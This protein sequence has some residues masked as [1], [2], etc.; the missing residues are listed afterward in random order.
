MIDWKSLFKSKSYWIDKIQNDLYGQV[1]QY[2][3]ENGM[4]KL[5]LAKQLGVSKGYVSQILNGQFDHKLSKL[6]ELYLAIGKAP[7][8][9]DADL[10]RYAAATAEGVPTYKFIADL[11][12]MQGIQSQDGFQSG[13]KGFM[14]AT[15]NMLEATFKGTDTNTDAQSMLSVQTIGA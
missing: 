14:E 5:D 8:I 3:K 10:R 9:I 7:L 13:E 4:N 2:M 6:V 11:C 1:E 12:E 15:Q